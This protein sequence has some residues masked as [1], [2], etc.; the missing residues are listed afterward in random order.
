M[1]D[2]TLS[3]RTIV[4][5]GVLGV[6]GIIA[7]SAGAHGLDN[8]F[9]KWEYGPELT[10]KRLAQF[11]TGVRYHMVHTVAL[12]AIAAIPFGSPTVRR[13]TVRFMIAGII[14]FSG[15]LYLL[16]LTNEPNYGM[17]APLGGL[18]WIVGWCGL[19]G[20]AQRHKYPHRYEKA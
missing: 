3:R 16:A 17:I 11:N 4:Y 12:I 10:E 15:S 20:M 8:L 18:C 1:I 13:W 2:E 5:A 7:A 14:L 19:I 6:V 9:A